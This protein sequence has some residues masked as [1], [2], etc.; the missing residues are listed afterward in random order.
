MG[1]GASK[2][3]VEAKSEMTEPKQSQEEEDN[4]DIP[5]LDVQGDFG[6][7]PD[8]SSSSG[9]MENLE[10]MDIEGYK[11]IKKLGKGASSIVVQMERDNI[12]Y[13]VKVCD[14]SKK[15]P[16]FISNDTHDPKEEAAL[17]LKFDHPNVVK[18]YDMYDDEEFIYIV[19]ELLNGGDVSSCATKVAKRL[20][21]TQIVSGLK[22]IHFQRIAHRD[23]KVDNILRAADG[24]VRIVDFS[25]S[26]FIPDG[27]DKLVLKM[28][29]TPAYQAPETFGEYPYNPFVADIW[30][31]GVTFYVMV[32]HEL[33]FKAQKLVDLQKRIAKDHPTFPEDTDKR[34]IDLICKML[35]KDPDKRITLEQIELHPW[36]RGTR[37]KFSMDSVPT[38]I[39]KTLT[40]DEK[41]NSIQR[42]SIHSNRSTG[43]SSH[44]SNSSK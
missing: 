27:V 3:Q 20:A 42:I 2:K 38:P 40:T 11:Y 29:G 5:L 39:Y 14:V 26:Q 23:I 43:S 6:E 13:A 24:S 9:S 21:L 32:F 1:C 17:L 10:I 18:V 15:R 44:R 12:Q 8:I 30:S 16:S 35:E 7:I 28:K 37:V 25:I 4:S 41:K 36:L 33:P 19:M 31:L 34:L 22:Y